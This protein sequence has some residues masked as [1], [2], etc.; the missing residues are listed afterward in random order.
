MINNHI[1]C[2]KQKRVAGLT[3]RITIKNH[4]QTEELKHQFSSTTIV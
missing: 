3:T 1:E 4:F 2:V